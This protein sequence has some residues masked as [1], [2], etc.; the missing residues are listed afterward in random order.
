MKWVFVLL[1]IVDTLAGALILW[2]FSEA[3]A[4]YI[5][6]YMLAKGSYFLLTGIAS[7]SVDPFLLLCVCDVATGLVLGSMALGHVF[8]IFH[9]IGMVSIL[10]GLFCT[11]YPLITLR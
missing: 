8:G 11:V 2:P 9:Y 4:L 6:V 10:K 3:L 1:G 5:I 7:H